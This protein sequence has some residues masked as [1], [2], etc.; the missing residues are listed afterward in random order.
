MP[1]TFSRDY[2]TT[3]KNFVILWEKLMGQRD[4]LTIKI[5]TIEFSMAEIGQ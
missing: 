3:M 1:S 5:S 4:V 2:P